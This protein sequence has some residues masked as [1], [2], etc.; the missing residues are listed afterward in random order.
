MAVDQGKLFLSKGPF[1]RLL[2]QLPPHSRVEMP[3]GVRMLML[4]AP[5]GTLLGHLD[6]EREVIVWVG[7]KKPG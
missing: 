4:K 5:D 3:P 6:T 1:L 7:G 2:E